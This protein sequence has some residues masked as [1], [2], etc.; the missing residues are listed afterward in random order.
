MEDK[1]NKHKN[2][3]SSLKKHKENPFMEQSLEE[4]HENVAKKYKTSSGT[5]QTAILHAIDENGEIKGH[6][7][8]L[9]QIEVDEKQFVKL[10]LSNLSNFF[11]KDIDSAGFICL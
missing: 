2:D 7:T 9:R 5:S 6:T 11:A 3:F 8:F 1:K 4:V 10:Y